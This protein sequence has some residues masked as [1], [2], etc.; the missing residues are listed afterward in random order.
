MRGG[1]DIVDWLARRQNAG[2]AKGKGMGSQ[3]LTPNRLARS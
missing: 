2:E 1:G 3:A